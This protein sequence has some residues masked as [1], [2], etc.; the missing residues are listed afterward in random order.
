MNRPDGSS[1]GL[2]LSVL[3]HS[4]FHD[5]FAP[6]LL[7]LLFVLVY[8]P[9]APGRTFSASASSGPRRATMTTEA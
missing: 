1:I 3:Q 4:P 7:L 6:G 9:L 5:F 2:P 8:W